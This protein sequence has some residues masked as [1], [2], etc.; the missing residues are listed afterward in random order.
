MAKTRSEPDTMAT[1]GG[2]RARD[3]SWAIRRRFLVWWADVGIVAAVCLAQLARLW[4]TGS[5]FLTVIAPGLWL[6][7]FVVLKVMGLLEFRRG[8]FRGIA[9]ARR[10]S[11]GTQG[12]ASGIDPRA[13][14][15]DEACPPWPWDESVNL[16]DHGI[17][18]GGAAS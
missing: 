13:A 11:P 15:A 6:A 5:D 3:G 14:V 9:D 2:S 12:G 8:W 16:H 7:A 1:D 4:Q 18:T 10:M 17:R